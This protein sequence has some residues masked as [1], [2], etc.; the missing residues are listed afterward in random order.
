M[1]WDERSGIDIRAKYPENEDLDQMSLIQV[2]SQHE[3]SGEVGI[4]SLTVGDT[5]LISYYS[6]PQKKVY[7]VIILTLS[8]DPDEFETCLVGVSQKILS[9]LKNE[10]YTEMLPALFTQIQAYQSFD[11]EQ[12]LACIYSDEVKQKIINRLREDGIVDK[13]ELKVWLRDMYRQSYLDIDTVLIELIKRGLIKISSVDGL[14][15]PS[16]LIFLIRDIIISR[17]QINLKNQKNIPSKILELIKKN[18][19]EY[20][21]KYSHNE[22]DVLKLVEILIQP[23]KNEFLKLMRKQNI[24]EINH[25]DLKQYNSLIPEFEKT[26]LIMTLEHDGEKF[27]ALQSDIQ[28]IKI[29]PSYMLNKIRTDYQNKVK[30]SKVL[31]EYLR[32]LENEFLSAYL[33]LIK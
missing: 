15:T 21:K 17:T 22:D 28:V 30:S 8:E 3:Y 29:L 25:P 1:K 5:N 10:E 9:N 13:S 18:S 11:E 12:L 32:I 16:I 6:G 31:M 4:I 20:L 7:I 2:Y 26:E 33:T 23:K 14:N 19:K 24:I 27:I